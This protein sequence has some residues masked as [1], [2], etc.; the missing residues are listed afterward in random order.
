MT[1]GTGRPAQYLMVQRD[2]IFAYDFF[3]KSTRMSPVNH[4]QKF[5]FGFKFRRYVSLKFDNKKL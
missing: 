5:K 2:D 1:E 3:I 4:L